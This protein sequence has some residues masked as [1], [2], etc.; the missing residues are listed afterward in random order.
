MSD[1]TPHNWVKSQLGHG[2][3]QCKYCYAT[4]REVAV[5]GDLNHCPDAPK[6]KPEGQ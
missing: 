6:A 1:K 5:I 2:E 4:N 3:A